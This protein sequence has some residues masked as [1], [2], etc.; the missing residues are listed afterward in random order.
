MEKENQGNSYTSRE[1][2]CKGS[3]FV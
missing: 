1:P 2:V 3:S